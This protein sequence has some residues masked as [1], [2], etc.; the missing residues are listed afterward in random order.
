MSDQQPAT[1]GVLVCGRL[2]KDLRATIGG[3]DYAELYTDLVHTGAAE[4]GAEVEVRIYD[5]LNGELPDSPSDCDA[6][7]ITGSQHDA[8]SDDPWIVDLRAFIVDLHR[9]RARTVGVCFGHQVVAHALGGRSGR[10]GT[11]KAGPQRLEVADTAWFAGGEVH[12][13]AMHQDEVLELPPDAVDIG[14]GTTATHAIYQVADNML[15]MQDHPE[16]EAP[17]VDALIDAR[18]DRIGPEVA[19]R[20]REMTRSTPVNNDQVAGWIARFLLN[21][22]T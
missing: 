5:A 21:R 16:F 10:S 1:V 9:H 11:W 14:S 20:G 7:I 17:L 2:S 19:S 8:H 18:A 13:N 12:L 15:C 3:A 22:T 6:W 4:A